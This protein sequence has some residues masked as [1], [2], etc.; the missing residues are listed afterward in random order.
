[1][2]TSRTRT[3]REWVRLRQSAPC[4]KCNTPMRWMGFDVRDHG[5]TFFHYKC[6]K[7]GRMGTKMLSGLGEIATHARS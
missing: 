5:A 4:A 7:C 2:I 6:E 3:I 1:M